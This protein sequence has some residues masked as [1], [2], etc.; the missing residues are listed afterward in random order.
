[1]TWLRKLIP[2]RV[3]YVLNDWWRRLWVRV[4]LFS[5][6]AVVAAVL[7][8]TIGKYIPY[9]PDISLASGSVDD[10]L[11]ILASSMLAVT[12][13]SVSIMVTAY[14]GATSNATPR[15]IRLLAQD[16]LAQ[17]ALATFVGSFLFSIV[18]IIGIA[19]GLY[20]D[21]GRI[22]LFL[23]TLGVI[24]IITWTLLRWINQ[25]NSFGRVSDVVQRIEFAASE[26]AVEQ[27]SRPGLGARRGPA[28]GRNGD[29]V[30]VLSR[31]SAYVRHM[32]VDALQK[33]AEKAGVLVE[34][35]RLPGDYTHAGQ[36]LVWVSG[37]ADAGAIC[38]CYSIGRERDFRQDL[39]Y[40]LIVL[41]EVASKALS[42]GINDPGTAIE[43]IRAGTRVLRR[44]HDA[45]RA[46]LV[47]VADRVYVPP[48]DVVAAYRQFFDPI[49][50]DGAALVEVQT[51]VQQSLTGLA[52]FGD[53][54][55]AGAESA[56]VLG[57]V[58][59]RLDDRDRAL[60]LADLPPGVTP[61]IPRDG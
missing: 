53:A 41:A 19:A 50:R 27:G 45:G 55:I 3:L 23:A 26:A 12:T 2:D 7:S 34:S 4:V 24:A 59:S 29:W 32:D 30:P 14:G 61:P 36:V 51:T 54:A 42:P 52:L 47:P 18:G 17:N 31:A 57:H 22:F 43:A 1:M 37:P 40:G 49:A 39:T 8:S 56:A 28:P 5:A 6:I 38:D 11:H 44:Y 21:Q 60:V 16:P 10:I 35:A 58:W 9:N 15:S 46:P 25:L 13:F 20:N 48:L 33:L